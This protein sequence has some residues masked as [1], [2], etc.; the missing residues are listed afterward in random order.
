VR[1]E[2][3]GKRPVWVVYVLAGLLLASGVGIY[4]LATENH[5]LA[6]KVKDTTQSTETLKGKEIPA[7]VYQLP[8]TTV[9]VELAAIE[10]TESSSEPSQ[11]AITTVSKV[12]S[13][14]TI[15]TTVKAATKVSET[16][17]IQNMEM[18]EDIIEAPSL[19][20]PIPT[21]AATPNA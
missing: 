20:T 21:P 2:S 7:T 12:A 14:Y 8:E 1:E 3:K 16:L 15:E 17:P 11:T 5:K 19:N 9:E 10:P 13:P 18:M 4:Y 6:E